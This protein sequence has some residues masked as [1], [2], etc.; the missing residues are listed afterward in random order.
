MN[1]EGTTT[2]IE[3]AYRDQVT[4]LEG[5]AGT[6][7]PQDYVFHAPTVV[8]KRCDKPPMLLSTASLLNAYLEA[9]R[10]CWDYEAESERAERER[11][12]ELS[13]KRYA[14]AITLLDKWLKD[15]SGYDEQTWPILKK[16]IERTRTSRRRRFSG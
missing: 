13:R 4:L 1:D 10:P 7:A 5:S 3:G 8:R 9:V 12:F 6:T 15:D 14:D 11:R 2:T 16:Q